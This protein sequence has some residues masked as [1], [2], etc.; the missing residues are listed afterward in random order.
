MPPNH[1]GM[2]QV[3]ASGRLLEGPCTWCVVDWTPPVRDEALLE[4]LRLTEMM[5][6]AALNHF[7]TAAMHR[8]KRYCSLGAGVHVERGHRTCRCHHP[9]GRH[10]PGL[11]KDGLP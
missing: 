7:P 10:A 8:K 6:L 9:L 1:F 5:G 11:T 4:P 3:E 2:Q